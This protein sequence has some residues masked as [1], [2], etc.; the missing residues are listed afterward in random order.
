MTDLELLSRRLAT[1]ERRF[2][3]MI[4]A[5]IAVG[6]G[7]TAAALMA[8]VRINSVPGEVLPSGQIRMPS[9]NKPTR[10]PVEEEVRARHFVLVD[11]KGRERASLVADSAGSVFL[12]MFDGTGKTRTSLSVSND[13]PGLILYDASGQ[14]RTIIG[15]TT[16]VGSHVNENGVAERGPASSIVL[17]DKS[18]KL[19]W[20]Q[21]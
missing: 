10:T 18:G 8:Q 17:F 16:L 11:D 14:Q 6:I 15:S 1:M 21:P 2:R 4:R 13:G 5:A 12:V 19:L 20:R 9:E 3:W 7:I